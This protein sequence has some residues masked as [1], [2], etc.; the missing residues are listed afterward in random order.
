MQIESTTF[1]TV[2][3]K[4]ARLALFWAV[5]GA[6]AAAAVVPYLMVVNPAAAARIRMPLPLFMLVQCLQ[7]GVALFALGWIG[8]RL[9]QPLGLDA[10]WTRALVYRTP[11]P[12]IKMSTLAGSC[13][14]GLFAGAALLVLDKVFQ[15]YMP[16]AAV[17]A[18][19]HAEL[20]MRLLAGF[21]GGI[22]EELLLRLFLM[23][24]IIWVLRRFVQKRQGLPS[25]G[26][27]VTGILAAA[28]IF[29]IGHL[30]AT[31]GVWPLTPMVV[32]RT[33]LLNAIGGVVLGWIYWRRGLEQAMCAHFCADIV[34]HV[35]GGA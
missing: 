29:G 19:L 17:P 23:T 3:N 5:L 30:P 12:A 2:P 31:A 24:L 21:Y 33:V 13:A 22:T 25:T 15:P 16:I 32:T 26:I 4:Q 14:L 7:M 11:M 9:G 8:L 6:L 34:V 10:P 20:W 35:I 27:V 1:A 18:A 28:I